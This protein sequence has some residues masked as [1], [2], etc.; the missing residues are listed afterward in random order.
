MTLLLLLEE[1]LTLEVEMRKA[2]KS[3]LT[4]VSLAAT[5]VV[6]V[7]AAAVAGTWT[8]LPG[9]P[10][11]AVNYGKITATDIATGGTVNCT[12]SSASATSM[13]GSG[14]SPD[15]LVSINSIKFDSPAN[16]FGWCVAPG[17]IAWE[18]TAQN[19]PWKLSAVA[20][21]SDGASGRV[22][23]V[24]LS[25]VGDD[26]C[27][28]TFGAPGGGPGQIDVTYVNAT[29]R[30]QVTGTNLV[31]QSIDMNC[32]QTLINVGDALKITGSFVISPSMTVTSP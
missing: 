16:R 9:G 6:A 11:T 24:V 27:H 4:S 5:A 28:T 2:G 1:S 3:A 22:T 17:D 10:V 12:N 19:L 30:V 26:G 32:D 25:N 18:V 15:N 23:G 29:H 14:L 31:V 13:S 8:V 20:A 7:T 21:N